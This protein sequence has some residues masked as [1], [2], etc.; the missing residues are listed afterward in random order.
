VSSFRLPFDSKSAGP[1]PLVGGPRVGGQA[2]YG[3]SLA[4][5]VIALVTL[6]ASCGKRTAVVEEIIIRTTAYSDI[7]CPR[8]TRRRS[9]NVSFS[10]L[11][12][13]FSRIGLAAG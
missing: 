3:N 8:S 13:T 7:V 5:P 6:L 2:V 10:G 11:F 1:P 12:T 4:T 9:L